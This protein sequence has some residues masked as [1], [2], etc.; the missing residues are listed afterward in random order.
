M[1]IDSPSATSAQLSERLPDPDKFEGD[2]KDLHHFVSQIK[3][4]MIVNYDCFLTPQSRMAYVTNHLKGTPYAQILLYI[5]NGVCQLSDYG[6]VLE[7][8]KCAFGDPNHA[9]NARNDLY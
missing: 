2:R 1:S 4:K 6:E 8:L 3:E 5:H 9:R 7:I